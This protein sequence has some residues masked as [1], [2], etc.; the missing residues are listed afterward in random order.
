MLTYIHAVTWAILE[1][2]NVNVNIIKVWLFMDASAGGTLLYEP[3]QVCKI[4]LA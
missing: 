2:T 3:K 4:I 1:R